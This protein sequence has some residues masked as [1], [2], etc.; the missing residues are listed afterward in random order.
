MLK[1]H[2][3]TKLKYLCYHYGTEESCKKYRGSGKYWTRH[4]YK[5]KSQ[6]DTYILF[7]SSDRNMI[8]L[9]GIFYSKK[10]DVVNSKEYANLTVE[11]AQTTAEPIQRPEV[12]QLSRQSLAKRIKEEGPTLHEKERTIKA[13]A[14]M[15]TSNSR[16][17]ARNTLVNRINNS[18]LSE[19]EQLRAEKRRQRFLRGEFTANELKYFKTISSRQKG[20][21]MSERLN[22]SN[23]I[24]KRKGKIAQ[25]IYGENYRNSKQIDVEIMVNSIVIDI[26]TV[27]DLWEKYKL[28]WLVTE[29]AKLLSGYVVSRRSKTTHRFENGDVIHIKYL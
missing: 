28:S 29:K 23:Y 27:K 18:G 17:K 12:R 16:A 8:A 24:D 15:S 14:A 20:K 5:H 7:S 6:I 9:M 26:C 4:Y 25:E 22:N 1:Q 3:N 21:T 19:H 10:W 2:Q 13:V 11:C